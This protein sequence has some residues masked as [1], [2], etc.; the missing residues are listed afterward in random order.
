ML[1]RHACATRRYAADSFRHLHAPWLPLRFAAAPRCYID[2]PL[3]PWRCRFDAAIDTRHTTDIR[4]LR[5][6]ML[7][8]SSRHREYEEQVI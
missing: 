8:A 5:H 6:A 4:Q 2:T 3:T 7:T 1:R